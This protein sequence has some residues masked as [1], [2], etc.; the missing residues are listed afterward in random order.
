MLFTHKED[1]MIGKDDPLDTR[2]GLEERLWTQE[3]NRESK[4]DNKKASTFSHYGTSF[5][6]HFRYDSQ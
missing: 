1:K 3:K 2:H 6:A 4:K 5:F